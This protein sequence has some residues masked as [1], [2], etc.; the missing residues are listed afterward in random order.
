M[1]WDHAAVSDE[2]VRYHGVSKRLTERVSPLELFFDLVFVLAIT[3]CTALMADD[4]TWAGLTR[5]LLV[6]AVLWWAWVGYAWLTSVIDPEED[7]VRLAV[8]VAMAAFLVVSLCIPQAFGD[9]GLLFALA[10]AVVRTGQIMLFVLGSP[11]DPQLRHSVIG[12]AISSAI[13]VTLLVIASFL[14][15][16]AQGALWALAIVL[17]VGG[18]FLFGSDGWK[19]V[20]G[21]FAERHGLIMIIALGESIVA[22]GVG[23]GGIEIGS[24]VISV[25]V[26]GVFLAAAMWWAY[27][28]VVAVAAERRLARTA[29]G[30]EQN[31]LA[32][33]AYSYMHLI[34][35]AGIVLTALGL[36]KSI[37]HVTDAL[38]LET[39]AALCGGV[40]LYLIGHVLFRWRVTHTVNRERLGVAVLLLAV[41]P[42][43]TQIPAWVSVLIVLVL[44]V[45]I[46]AY[47]T[48]AWAETRDRIR[49]RPDEP[50]ADGEI[51]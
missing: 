5:G 45:G 49:H 29:P 19:L 20:P 47:E 14:D 41:I 46:V 42:V 34:M 2:P 8:F 48:T 38:H 1:G 30:R 40:A 39:A 33:D 37:A 26:M 12:L 7:A 44:M 27:F 32:R 51:R 21:H 35:V 50:P 11:D 18:P 13:G 24:G 9:L 16:P 17:D 23:A 25:A 36:K 10:Y 4:P 22:I 31:D 15:G 3:Q 28:D 6:L 43:A